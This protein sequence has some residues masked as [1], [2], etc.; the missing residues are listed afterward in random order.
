MSSPQRFPRAHIAT[1]Q[2]IYRLVEI[3]LKEGSESSCVARQSYN[4]TVTVEMEAVDS[5]RQFSRVK[6]CMN[7]IGHQIFP[8]A[9]AL[10]RFKDPFSLSIPRLL[11]TLRYFHDR[12]NAE[13][14][15]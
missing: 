8:K 4:L 15:S 13:G 2:P 6:S 5:G 11:R 12:C 1:I 7:S 10:D 9:L 14:H 3:N